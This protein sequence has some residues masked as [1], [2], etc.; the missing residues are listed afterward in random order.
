MKRGLLSVKRDTTWTEL[1]LDCRGIVRTKPE[2]RARVRRH[3]KRRHNRETER[4]I[5]TQLRDCV[6]QVKE[7]E[8]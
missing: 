3:V 6:T 4:E 7:Y 5:D 2:F 8:E 1:D